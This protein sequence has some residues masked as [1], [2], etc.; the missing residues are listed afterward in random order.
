MILPLDRVVDEAL[1]RLLVVA[2]LEELQPELARELL[3]LHA[4]GREVR[5]LAADVRALAAIGEAVAALRE[6]GDQLVDAVFRVVTSDEQVRVVV[7]Q[8]IEVG[9]LLEAIE[10]FPFTACLH[11]VVRGTG[12]KH[13]LL[14][15]VAG[16]ETALMCRV[17]GLLPRIG[18][19]VEAVGLLPELAVAEGV[20]GL[21]IRVAGGDAVTELLAQLREALHQLTARDGILD[22]RGSFGEHLRGEIGPLALLE[23]TRGGEDRLVVVREE[24]RDASPRFAGRDEVLALVLLELRE[25]LLEEHLRVD[26]ALDRRFLLEQVREIVPPLGLL[27]EAHER[28]TRCL[29]LAVER[30]ELAPGG[31]G[32]VDVAQV[33]FAQAGDLA[34]ALLAALRLVRDAGRRADAR[35]EDV[36]ELTV[37]ALRTEVVLGPRERLGVRGIAV[38]HFLVLCKRFGL[39]AL[40]GEHLRGIED[41]LHLLGRHRGP[42]LVRALDLLGPLDGGRCIRDAG[43]LLRGRHEARTLRRRRLEGRRVARALMASPRVAATIR[44]DVDSGHARVRC[45]GDELEATLGGG[46]DRAHRRRV[47]SAERATDF[48]RH[49]AGRVRREVRVV[50]RVEVR[51]LGERSRVVRVELDAAVVAGLDV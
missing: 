34:E 50:A 11:E 3:V 38:E 23:Q 15:Q 10:R 33:A 14:L 4:R 48:G 24:P 29:V 30:E 31:D 26:V 13:R 9:R 19:A 51:L 43:L 12:E 5:G 36:A 42:A 8:R 49:R 20:G 45:A 35:E 1:E 32:A 25:L 40:A 37:V 39:L 44:D 7:V 27:E 6:E 22:R 2:V 18:G 21:G 41:A 28:G 16:E 17:G 46:G 47:R